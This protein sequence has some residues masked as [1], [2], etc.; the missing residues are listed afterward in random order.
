MRNFNKHKAGI[1]LIEIIIAS[2]IIGSVFIVLLSS[3]QNSVR[4]S[5][6]SLEQTQAAFLLEE[7][8]EASKTIRDRGWTT[9]SSL[10]LNTP[11]YLSWDGTEWSFTDTPVITDEFTR[12]VTFEEVLRDGDDDIVAVGGTADTGTLKGTV[13]VSWTTRENNIESESLIFYLTNLE[14]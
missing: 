10:I 6:R 5:A 12:T 11:Y 8:A 13:T 14:I 1:S 7:G 4:I 3:I 9:V 2:A